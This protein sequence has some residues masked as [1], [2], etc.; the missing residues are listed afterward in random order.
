MLKVMLRSYQTMKS[1]YFS[2]VTQKTSTDIYGVY[3]KIELIKFMCIY[4]K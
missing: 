1:I 3:I 2:D 4:I